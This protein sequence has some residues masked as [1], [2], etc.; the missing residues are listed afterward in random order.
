MR[1][2]DKVREKALPLLILLLAASE[3]VWI[4]LLRFNAVNGVRAVLT[5]V[6][7]LGT[8][9]ALFAL[10]AL[11]AR[12]IGNQRS[13]L[14]VVALGAVLFWLTML[15]AG[16]PVQLSWSEM[17]EALHADIAGEEVAFERFLLYDHDIWRYIGDG[18]V[19]ARRTSSSTPGTHLSS[20]HLP[21]A[22]TLIQCWSRRWRLLPISSLV[23]NEER[24]PFLLAWP[25]WQS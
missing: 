12:Q 16:L 13:V 23:G 4:G 11:V 10:S 20:K 17:V 8:L 6:D 14:L 24:P 3:A 22:A 9:L 21:R 25:S 18:H 19:A 1:I 2:P 5:F 15:P 7:L